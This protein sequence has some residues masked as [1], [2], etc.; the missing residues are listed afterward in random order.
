MSPCGVFMKN[1]NVKVNGYDKINYKECCSN[2]KLLSS[3]IKKFDERELLAL[4][5]IEKEQADRPHILQR[6]YSRF[7]KLRR[8]KEVKELFQ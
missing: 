7:S 1:F 5:I 6:L 3:H 2:W 8:N 4:I